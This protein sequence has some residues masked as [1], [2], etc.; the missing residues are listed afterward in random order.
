MIAQLM[1]VAASGGYYVA[2]TADHVQAYPTTITGSIGV[3]FAGVE[4]SGLME[5]IGVADQTLVTGPFKDAGSPLRPLSDSEREQLRSVI[6]DLFARF[7]AVVEDGRPELTT[8]Q[9]QSLADGR[10]YS[11]GQA[12]EAGLIDSVGDLPSAVELAK[13]AAGLEEA[14]VIR[15]LRPGRRDTTLFSA[16]AP[17]APRDP[18]SRVPGLTGP[19]FL[20]LWSPGSP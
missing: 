7:V 15:Y 8:E 1:G 14:R 17:A 3:I 13:E 12:L 2:M 18:W 19:S 6:D 16:E 10:I 9:V 11:A 4:V 20:Y 5:K